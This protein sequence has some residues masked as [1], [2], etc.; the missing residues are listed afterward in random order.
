MYNAVLFSI[1]TANTINANV[2]LGKIYYCKIWNGDTL[3]RDLVAKLD[4][5]NTPCMY[6]NVSKTY[7]Y[8]QGTGSFTYGTD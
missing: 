7:Y 2:F 6:D 5:S 4:T 3:V 8:K 1:N